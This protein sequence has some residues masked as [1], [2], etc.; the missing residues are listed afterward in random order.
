MKNVGADGETVPQIILDYKEEYYKLIT[1]LEKVLNLQCIAYG[2]NGIS[3]I[4]NLKELASDN[5]GESVI[6]IPLCIA[7]RIVE[8]L[9]V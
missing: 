9:N 3:F 2:N 8:N 7:I 4:D 1:P 6:R 5:K